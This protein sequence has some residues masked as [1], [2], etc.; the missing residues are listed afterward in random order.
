M[1]RNGLVR[2]VGRADQPSG[3][4]G[5]YPEDKHTAS[6]QEDVQKP[7]AQKTPETEPGDQQAQ[8]RN[9]NGVHREEKPGGLEDIFCGSKLRACPVK[10]G[11]EQEEQEN[12]QGVGL[13]EKFGQERF[14]LKSFC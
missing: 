6:Q 8:A 1:S 14:L 11:K 2:A 5:R 10:N 9:E 3:R 7:S 12:G 13:A 4:K